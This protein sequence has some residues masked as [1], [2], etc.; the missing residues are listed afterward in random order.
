MSRVLRGTSNPRRTT[1]YCVAAALLLPLAAL[2]GCQGAYDLPLPGGA[3]MGG[4]SYQVTVQF[5][6][7]MDLVPQSAV[8][9]DEV[10]VGRV[11]RIAVDGWTARVTVRLKDSV[12]LPA[13]ATAE[14]KQTSLLGEKYVALSPPEN[15][16]SQGKLVNGAVIPIARSTRTP[17][18][19]E[20]LGALSLLLNGGGVAQLKVITTELNKATH[21]NE[22]AIRDLVGRL[23]TFVGGLDA[24]KSQ[25]V[26]ALDAVD[27]LSGRLA[28]QRT[29]LA[30]ALDHLPAGLKVLADQRAQLTK[31]L[32]ALD[33][34][35]VVGTKVVRASKADTVA[36]LAALKPT[37]TELTKAGDDLPNSLRL[38]LSFP[39]PDNAASGAIKGDYANLHATLDLNLA[40][41]LKQNAA[42]LGSGA[43]PA[44][45]A[46]PGLPTQPALPTLPGLCIPLVPCGSDGTS[47]FTG[48]GSSTPT[49]PDLAAL[50]KSLQL[51]GPSGGPSTGPP[52]AGLLS[53]LL[54][55][56]GR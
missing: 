21:G 14:L 39:F 6:D 40:E 36:N 19:E 10:T 32:T 45:P 35:G 13:N 49:T 34:L 11:E 2:T 55:G 43:G 31:M 12:Q 54:G 53:L 52:D 16:A 30:I 41:L 15:I 29:D 28:A 33:R 51:R 7:V 8:K 37:L 38:L 5:A 46:L 17:E 22:A 4:K 27:Q 23:N 20:V 44:L 3:A 1:R 50:L 48:P 24:Q 47:S 9:V 18:V 25:I 26:T 56:L 42:A